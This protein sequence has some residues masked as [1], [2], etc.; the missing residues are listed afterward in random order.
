MEQPRTYIAIDLKSFYASVECAERGLDP[1]T[2][3]LVVADSTRTE[4]TICL[5]VSPSL[6]AFGIPGRPRLF[7]VVQRVRDINRERLSKAI[8]ERRAIRNEKGKFSFS[9][10]SFDSIA[11]ANDISLELSYIVA[12]PRMAYYIEYSTRIY[13]IYLKYI[14][15]EDIH[16]YSIDEVFI[17]ATG[18]LD[19]YR[20][21]PHDLAMT[22]IRDVLYNT[23]ITATAGI[24]SN[25]YLAKVAMDIVAKHI[26]PDKDGVRIAELDEQT[27][28]EKL[29]SH[30]PLTDFW[31]VGKGYARKLEQMGLFTMGDVAKCSTGQ[32]GDP[33][34]E[35]MLYKAFG[36]NAELLIDHAWGWEP[37]T[38]GKIKEYKPSS[39]SLGSGQ[40][41]QKP[42]TYDKARLVVREMTEALVLDLVE[43]GLV[44]DQMVLTVGYDRESL[45]GSRGKEYAG[46][47]TI[48]HYGRSVPKQAH[49]S[50]NL[51]CRSSSTKLIMEA[52]MGLYERVVNEKLLIRRLNITANN[53]TPEQAI[54]Q[55][56]GQPE[57]LDLFTDYAELEEKRKI[58][59]AALEKEKRLQQAI[60]QVRRKFGKNAML[61]GMDLEEDA[62]AIQRNGQIGGHKA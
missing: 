22:M 52:V 43:K 58:E 42:Y 50:V 36:V 23:G 13:N 12:P 51:G 32:A 29:W 24:G 39:N 61:K 30:R 56:A 8:R 31:R 3:N 48:D 59:A 11:I 60:I 25:L 27:Y 53:V 19:T 26:Q 14:A 44:A 10:A 4:K 16:V 20:M 6:K 37:C 55:D 18:Y 7:E 49:G 21:T 62:T 38:I 35:D 41:L 46:E 28:R 5:A 40:V 57:Q 45:N 47:I 2:T 15:P 33:Y 9:T 34:N 54:S 1:L 17:D